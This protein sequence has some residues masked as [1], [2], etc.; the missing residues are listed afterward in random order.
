MKKSQD[1]SR[2]EQSQTTIQNKKAQNQKNTSPSKTLRLNA[3]T[4]IKSSQQQSSKRQRCIDSTEQSRMEN[5]T[6]NLENKNPKGN[7]IATV[8]SKKFKSNQEMEKSVNRLSKTPSRQALQTASTQDT[9]QSENQSNERIKNNTSS[10]SQVSIQKF[11]SGN[12]NHE[13]MKKRRKFNKNEFSFTQNELAEI[14]KCQNTQELPSDRSN[15]NSSRKQSLNNSARKSP[16]KKENEKQRQTYEDNVR[17]VEQN[18]VLDSNLRNSK[19][20]VDLTLWKNAIFYKSIAHVKQQRQKLKEKLDPSEINQKA[21]PKVKSNNRKSLHSKK[22]QQVSQRC[23]SA[24]TKSVMIEQFK[25]EIEIQNAINNVELIKIVVQEGSR[26]EN[27][28]QEQVKPQI[29]EKTNKYKKYL[30]CSEQNPE[31]YLLDTLSRISP[32][33]IRQISEFKQETQTVIS[34]DQLE[35][36]AN[37]FMQLVNIIIY[38]RPE[39][40]QGWAQMQSYCEHNYD[41]YQHFLILKS[42]SDLQKFGIDSI[43]ETDQGY[44]QKITLS[45]AQEWPKCLFILYLLCK[46]LIDYIYD[47]YGY[48]PEKDKSQ[49]R[50]RKSRSQMANRIVML[51]QIEEDDEGDEE[52]QQRKITPKFTQ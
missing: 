25:K 49:R 32:T 9:Q 51:E 11:D 35:N 18:Q 39:L 45:K 34:K 43:I 44:L 22:I 8:I 20:E 13:D 21:K 36:L 19:N 46:A 1:D 10:I 16:R 37:C 29:E 23:K 14:T 17:K 24:E 12:N 41:A 5:D 42:C 47:L 33:L 48:T 52:Q 3:H 2:K 40:M 26:S 30:K 4:P 27:Q 28:T 50:D 7:V 31:Q 6:K 15:K 38:E